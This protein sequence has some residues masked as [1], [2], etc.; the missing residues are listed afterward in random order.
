MRE[1]FF[2]K[3]FRT[4]VFFEPPQNISFVSTTPRSSSEQHFIKMRSILM[5]SL[6]I[7]FFASSL[8]FAQPAFQPQIE[9][10]F[11]SSPSESC[12]ELFS[13]NRLE[14][15]RS[16]LSVGCPPSDGE[17]K[18]ASFDCFA[19]DISYSD[20]NVIANGKSDVIKVFR[21]ILSPSF[22]KY[23]T[24]KVLEE[25]CDESEYIATFEMNA[26]LANGNVI[27][28]PGISFI[29]FDEKNDDKV[30]RWRDYLSELKA[31]DYIPLVKS[32]LKR[33]KECLLGNEGC[34]NITPQ[35]SLENVSSDYEEKST[36]PNEISSSCSKY[37]TPERL[38]VA[39]SIVQCNGGD[40]ED[41]MQNFADEI[42]YTDGNFVAENKSAVKVVFKNM[43]ETNF[44]SRW[45]IS[46]AKEVC[47]SDGAYIPRWS[48]NAALTNEALRS[49]PGASLIK[50]EDED[51]ATFQQDYLPELKIY[52]KTPVLGTL[53][54]NYSAALAKCLTSDEGC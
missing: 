2:L 41:C 12:E 11:P 37:F 19:E 35:S 52:G 50:F 6:A 9:V 26:T 43:F 53:L 16:V 13:E 51:R 36:V 3:Y 30:V 25:F 15:A 40:P 48:V 21:N 17:G 34:G 22:T 14:I 10:T 18:E 32:L 47:T 31:Y 54:T 33:K 23:W 28:A 4:L 20:G 7:L 46:I 45:S 42:V 29:E 1:N 44:A 5:I 8:A 27:N 24:V 49:A 39:R 38:N